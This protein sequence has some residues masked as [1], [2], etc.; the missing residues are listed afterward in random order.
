MKKR[1]MIM[2]DYSP[3]TK[4]SIVK[5][6]TELGRFSGTAKLHPEDEDTESKIFGCYLAELRAYREY[7]K[8]KKALVSAE[9][10][11]LKDYQNIIMSMKEYDEKHFAASKLR[12]QIIEKQQLLTSITEQLKSLQTTL[13]RADTVRQEQLKAL[14]VK[15]DEIRNKGDNE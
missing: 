12:R 9:I 1:Q 8:Q 3:L 5:I 14:K 10:K 7:F 15:L 11:A 13:A 6:K 4:C 2:A